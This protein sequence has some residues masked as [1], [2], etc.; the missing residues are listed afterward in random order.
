MMSGW[1]AGEVMRVGLIFFVV[2]GC[3]GAC[4]N[5][6]APLTVT[7]A[8]LCQHL[9]DGGCPQGADVDCEESLSLGEPDP[10]A[11]CAS[12]R[13]ELRRCYWIDLPADADHELA[14]DPATPARTKPKRCAGV[15]TDS[16]AS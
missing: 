4:E 2:V 12:Q 11:A 10:S 3:S 8:I 6:A 13:N 15:K 7:P 9:R 16:T 1:R 14:S 5:G